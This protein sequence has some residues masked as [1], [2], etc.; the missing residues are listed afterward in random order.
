MAD[1][2]ILANMEWI[3]VIAH[4]QTLTDK[5][6]QT[7]KK[8]ICFIIMNHTATAQNELL[9]DLFILV[10]HSKGQNHL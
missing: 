2:Q 3:T 1:E 5:H 7:L 8:K 4:L 9:C 10:S 6:M